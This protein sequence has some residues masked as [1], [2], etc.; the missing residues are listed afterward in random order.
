M[1]RNQL[2]SLELG[3]RDADWRRSVE[4]GGFGLWNNP[5]PNDP[6]RVYQLGPEGIEKII[7]AVTPTEREYADMA[8]PIIQKTGDMLADKFLEINGYEMPRTES[9]AYWRKDVMASERGKTDE[10]TELEKARLAD[11]QFKGMDH[12][13]NGQAALW[14]EHLLWAMREMS[15][16]APIM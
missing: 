5:M 8:V 14:V 13:A 11:G 1:S 16:G 15:S 12:P 3:W 10:Q 6:N 7:A 2:I 9:G 4:E